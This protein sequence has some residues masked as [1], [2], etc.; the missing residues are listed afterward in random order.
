M[1]KFFRENSNF[2]TF[3]K[4]FSHK[5]LRYTVALNDELVVDWLMK[6][7]MVKM[8]S[9]QFLFIHCWM[10]CLR[11]LRDKFFIVT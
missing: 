10:F 7:F 4:I 8:S 1:Q 3:A 11:K 2:N 6:T 9:C 5:I